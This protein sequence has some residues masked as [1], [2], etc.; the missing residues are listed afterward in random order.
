[1]KRGGGSAGRPYWNFSIEQLEAEVENIRELNYVKALRAE[2]QFAR[3]NERLT[4]MI[5]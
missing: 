4:W 5:C 3:A 1:M 2:L